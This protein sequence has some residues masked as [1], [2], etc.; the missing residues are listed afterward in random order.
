MRKNQT[1]YFHLPAHLRDGA[2]DLHGDAVFL[3]EYA[4]KCY[5]LIVVNKLK[6]ENKYRFAF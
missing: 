1:N 4:E 6:K 5:V 2:G 3:H